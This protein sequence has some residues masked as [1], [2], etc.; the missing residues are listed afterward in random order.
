MTDERPLENLILVTTTG[1]ERYM[2]VHLLAKADWQE[3]VKRMA[4]PN[5]HTHLFSMTS[6]KPVEN[7]KIPAAIDCWLLPVA[8]RAPYLHLEAL[9]QQ[10]RTRWLGKAPETIDQDLEEIV[11]M[12]KKVRDDSVDVKFPLPSRGTVPVSQATAE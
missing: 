6:G 4:L 9:E 5:H 10:Y 8:H 7:S 1:A 3:V 2:T 12:L 11:S